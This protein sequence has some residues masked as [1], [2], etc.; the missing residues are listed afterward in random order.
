MSGVSPLWFMIVMSE[1]WLTKQFMAGMC[2][3]D[4]QCAGVFPVSEDSSLHNI[5]PRQT[6]TR[7][8]ES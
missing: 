5:R 8:D 2:P 3:D 4:A 1:P 7:V 6:R